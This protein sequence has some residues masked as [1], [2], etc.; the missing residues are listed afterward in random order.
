MDPKEKYYIVLYVPITWCL[1]IAHGMMNTVIGPSQLYLAQNVGL[2]LSQIN[3]VWTF[4]FI[5][6][7]AGSFTAGAVMKT[8]LK[9][10][11]MKVSVMVICGLVSGT[12]MIFLPFITDATLLFG[13]RLI[14]FFVLAA[15][16]T[17]DTSMLVYMLGAVKAR[18]FIMA[19][20]AF[21]GVGFLIAT[22][23]VK[24]FL[25][26]ARGTVC[27]GDASPQGHNS[28]S[29]VVDASGESEVIDTSMIHWPF[30]IVGSFSIFAS[31][32]LAFL[33]CLPFHIPVFEETRKS[34]VLK[35][36]NGSGD[37]KE[38]KLADIEDD[39]APPEATNVK[40]QAIFI[41]LIF[42]YYVTTC[43]IERIFQSMTYSFG[44]CGPLK[45]SPSAAVI[46]DNAYNGGFM[47]GRI[48][49]ILIAKFIEP[50]RLVVISLSTC[51]LASIFLTIVSD[52][53]AIGLYLG[54]FVVGFFLAS[55]FGGCVNWTAKKIDI[56]G[57]VS[58]AFFAGCG[59]GG[60]FTPIL[61]GYLFDSSL[62]PMSIMYLACFS[63]VLQCVIFAG[64]W[65]VARYNQLK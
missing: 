23:L 44:L 37:F 65:T 36:V 27:H 8:W 3:F 28:S 14:Q 52:F 29:S 22:L 15:L 11:W 63:C 61:C 9:K 10:S 64:A 5:G 7:V 42:A 60:A 2:D 25:P 50:S 40:I 35:E 30:V 21:I 24:P 33:L 38:S 51:L 49:S 46:T 6:F 31:L 39:E 62:G 53:S 48:L 59:V 41:V 26:E 55:E 32:L 4:G 20:H 17:A 13:C 12:C 57:K 47:S 16:I 19:L 1:H 45:L 56:T 18:P 43:G 58:S 54:T 34:Q